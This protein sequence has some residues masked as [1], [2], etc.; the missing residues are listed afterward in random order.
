LKGGEEEM[1]R[2]SRNK[3]PISTRKRKGSGGAS[4]AVKISVLRYLM[5]F[6]GRKIQK[7]VNGKDEGQTPKRGERKKRRGREESITKRRQIRQ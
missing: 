5:L 6:G 7:E 4:A 1:R 3:P 2:V